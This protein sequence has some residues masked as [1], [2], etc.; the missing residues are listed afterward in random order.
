[1]PWLV[2]L[3]NAMAVAE[4]AA[5]FQ[6]DGFD[7]CSAPGTGCGLVLA[8]ARSDALLDLVASVRCTGARVLVAL[9]D[10]ATDID[11]W[12]LLAAGAGDVVS[13]ENVESIRERLA[14]W[15]EVD[16]LLESAD[17]LEIACGS[18]PAWRA[19]LREVVEIARFTCSSMLITGETGTG[20]E[21]VARLAHRLDPHAGGRELELVD[22]TT[23]VPSLSGSEFF[24]HTKGAFTGATTARVGAFSRADGGS[25]FLDEVGELPL[26]MQAELLRVVQEGTFKPVG[27]DAWRTTSFRLL[28]ATN[29]DL[30]AEAAEGRFRTDLYFRLAGAMVH[31]PPLRERPDDIVPL[32]RRFFA[33]ARGQDSEPHLVP[34]VAQLLLARSYPGNVRDLRQLAV[35]AATRHVG[36]GP[37]TPGDIPPAD[38]PAT[39]TDSLPATREPADAAPAADAVVEAAV[40]ELLG[41]GLGL[42]ELKAAVADTATRIALEEAGG[43]TAAARLLGVSRRAVDYRKA[44]RENGSAPPVDASSDASS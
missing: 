1:M 12:E 11:P 25:L 37:V 42:K 43:P 6:E 40:R 36:D 35:R 33:E 26:P 7:A 22:C 34:T 28:A 15:E 27:G 4:A 8:A 3:S 31:L 30:V 14:R 39:G 44:G 13:V 5:I 38:R 23:V 41:R 29:R 24:G 2:S 10:G 21:V 19:A 32:F 16:R 9:A 17:V 20:K 18:A